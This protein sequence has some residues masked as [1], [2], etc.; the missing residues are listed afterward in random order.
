MAI[1]P[2]VVLLNNNMLY[3][4]SALSYHRFYYLYETGFGGFF[5]HKIYIEYVKS[6]KNHFGGEYDICEY[7]C[8]AKLFFLGMME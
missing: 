4:I 7:E 5:E 1:R 3:I 6:T 8:M 2:S